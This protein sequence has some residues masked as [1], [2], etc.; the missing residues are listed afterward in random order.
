MKRT[1]LNILFCL[2]LILVVGGSPLF[3]NTV[4]PLDLPFEMGR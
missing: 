3:D 2:S 4:Q 1:C